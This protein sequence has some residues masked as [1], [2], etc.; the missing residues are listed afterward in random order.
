MQ[1][2]GREGGRGN[3]WGLGMVV[4]TPSDLFMICQQ[5]TYLL[6]DTVYGWEHPVYY[7][8]IHINEGSSSK[9]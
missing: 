5:C 2:E 8:I 7:L 3:E 4:F 6:D 9:A 1:H